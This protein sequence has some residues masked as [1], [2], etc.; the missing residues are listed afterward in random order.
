[1][2]AARLRVELT[3][4]EAGIFT[5]WRMIVVVIAAAGARG[6]GHGWRGGGCGIRELRSLAPN[7]NPELLFAVSWP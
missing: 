2:D 7:S 6:A 3:D 4:P 5:Y 1:M